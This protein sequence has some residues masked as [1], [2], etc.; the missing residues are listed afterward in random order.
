M[1]K[2]ISHFTAGTLAGSGYRNPADSRAANA[3]ANERGPDSRRSLRGADYERQR[4]LTSHSRQVTER[5]LCERLRQ[6]RR[7]QPRKQLCL[8]GQIVSSL[9]IFQTA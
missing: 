8:C 7:T 9:P 3:N 1:S 6:S 4:A 5:L 2:R